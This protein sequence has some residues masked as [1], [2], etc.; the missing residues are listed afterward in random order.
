MSARH[1]FAIGVALLLL[2]AAA[3]GPTAPPGPAPDL[4]CDPGCSVVWACPPK[5]LT[6]ACHWDCDCSAEL[7][8]GGAS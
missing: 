6:T 5:Y 7:G 8:A 2:A 4:S 1:M 3:C